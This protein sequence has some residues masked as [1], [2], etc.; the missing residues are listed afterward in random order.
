MILIR[1][2]AE[3]LTEGMF[4]Q[5]LIWLLEILNKIESDNIKFDVNTKSYG[6]LI[7]SHIVPLDV[8]DEVVDEVIDI[9]EY[10]KTHHIDFDFDMNSYNRA[11]Y[12]WNKYFT[13]SDIVEKSVPYIETEKTLGV[14][15]RGTD[16]NS[17][18][19]Q[20]NPISQEDFLIIVDEFLQ[21]HENFDSIYVASDEQ[22]FIESVKRRY[23]GKNIIEYTHKREYFRNGNGAISSLVDMI[24]L[25]KCDIIIKTSSALSN[26]SKIIN[27]NV[28]VYATSAMKQKWFP[29]GLVEQYKT[30][31]PDVIDILKRTMNG[32]VYN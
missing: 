23:P 27:P 10:K 2:D 11:N 3:T 7:P 21:T 26:F 15:Y 18:T 30:T 19:S 6:N 16:K 29:A 8:V 24:S 1:S 13:F 17:D 9:L 4:G 5:C 20:T 31:S 14:H 12:I 25:S 22:D 32:H 28:K